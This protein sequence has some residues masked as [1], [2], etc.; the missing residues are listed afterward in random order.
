MTV[1]PTRLA[2]LAAPLLVVLVGAG[3]LAQGASAPSSAPPAGPGF[4]GSR[5]W[6]H[7]RQIVSQGPRPSGS[8][9]LRQTRAYITR[10]VSSLGLTVQ[11]QPFV[12]QTPL[13]PVQMTNLIVRL[14]GTRA[15]RIVIGGHYDTKLYTDFAFVGA[16]DGGSSAAFLIE[17]TRALRNRPRQFTYELVWFDGEEA[18]R[19]EWQNP[20]NTYG[21]RHYVQAAQAAG[22]VRSLRGMILVDMI[23]ER[24]PRF[25]RE[26]HSTPW[27]KDIVWRTAAELGHGE[28]FQAAETP[29][30]DDHM[31]FLEAG[32]PSVNIIDLDY[33]H[34]H[35]AGDTLD[36]LAARSLQV[37]GDVL[38][39]ALP[40]IE[41]RL[42]Q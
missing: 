24:N 29:I 37:V 36:K 38:L 8:V 32:V 26:S 40:K 2:R 13:G 11:E 35:A 9:A 5:A 15:D 19:P 16:N 14:P 23:G 18:R 31:R 39:E 17:L 41:K 1:R 25:L 12:A 4:D 34:W 7:L 3:L 42:L 20:D 22:A 10:Q 30:E 6:E 33:P 21:S 28:V 27:L